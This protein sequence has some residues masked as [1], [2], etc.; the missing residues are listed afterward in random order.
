MLT[1]TEKELLLYIAEKGATY[2]ADVQENL[3]WFSSQAS[4]YLKRLNQMGLIE[5]NPK[6]PDEDQ[7]KWIQNCLHRNKK[8]ILRFVGKK[9]I[10]NRMSIYVRAK[11]GK[12]AEI[13]GKIQS[14]KGGNQNER[15]GK[16]GEFAEKEV[17]QN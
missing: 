15:K 5:L 2:P 10:R 16:I 11:D 4:N 17:N 14:E 1:E 12:F 3:G 8:N 13:V 7:L 9:Q 6:Y